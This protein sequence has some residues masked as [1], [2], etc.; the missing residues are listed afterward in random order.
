MRHDGASWIAD[1][2]LNNTGS[3][4]G[5]GTGAPTAE[6][7]LYGNTP[8]E[9]IESDISAGESDI[10]LKTNAGTYDYL[11][12]V[13]YGPTRPG[14][15]AGGAIPAAGLS[16]L[17][18]GENAG[19]LLLQTMAM[20]PMYFATDNAL[21]MEITGDGDFMQYNANNGSLM[22]LAYGG[23]SGYYFGMYDSAGNQS[24]TLESDSDTGGFMSLKRNATNDGFLV[25]GNYLGLEGTRVDILG[26]TTGITLDASVEGDQSVMLPPDALT[27]P[28]IL[29]EPGVGSDWR[30]VVYPLDTS[31]TTLAGRTV[32]V[33]AA[34]YVIVWGTAEVQIDHTNGTADHGLFGVSAN[35]V[36][37]PSAQ[38]NVLQLDAGLAT[39]VYNFPV[40]VHGVFE[41]TGPGSYSYYLLGAESSGEISVNKSS[42]AALYIP[43]AYGVVDALS[44]PYVDSS[45]DSDPALESAEAREMS[46]ARI[47]RE[48]SAM[49][50]RIAELETKLGNR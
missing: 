16:R 38:N 22:S 1:T 37:Y 35:D 5:I 50:E 39:G 11:K 19:G 45:S 21:R 44:A 48:L 28:E 15:V 20:H 31:P 14:T 47:E 3:A 29:D 8:K 25:N 4:V 49:R 23:P 41:V 34:G 7:H 10:E 33:P 6:L 9:R 40:T 26:A 43:T 46:D 12:L 2:Y 24:G 32:T 17:E 42:M 27:A 36:S 13:K 18:V 30:A